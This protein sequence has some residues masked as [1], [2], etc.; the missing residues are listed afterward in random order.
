[1]PR[2]LP[3]VALLL[4]AVPLAAQTPR[5][6]PVK[7]AASKVVAVTVYQNTALVTREVTL[8]EAAG[9]TEVVVSPLPPQT[10]QSS[11]YAEGGDG[12]RVLSARYRTRAIAEDTREEVR[13]LEAQLK[14]LARKQ[15]Q[16]QADHKASQQNG[17]FLTKL[18][19]FTSGALNHLSDKGQLDSEKVIAL[20]KF[21]Q[22]DR[23][24]RA[25]EEVAL[26]QQLELLQEQTEFA[27]RQLAEVSG[28]G[29][30]TE[31]DAVVVIDKKAGAGTVRLN[32]LVGQANWRPQYKLRAPA[33]DGEKVAVEYLAAVEQQ[34]G[35]DWSDVTLSL[36]TAQPLLN[37]APPDLRALEVSVGGPGVGFG[38]Q[39]EGRP[40]RPPGNAPVPS[41]PTAGGGPGG[42]GMP[43]QSAY[44]RDL[45]RQSQELRAQATFNYTQKKAAEGADLAN[46]AAALEQFKDLL[47]SSDDV[48]KNRLTAI[49]DSVARDGPSVTFHLKGRLSLPSRSDEQVL[50][51]ARLELAPKFYYKAVPVLTQ[52][53]YRLADLVNTSEHVLL[54][55]EA[56]MYLGTDFV[57]Q[58]RVPLVA[59]GKPFTVGFGV[60]PQLQVSR[61]LLDKGRT[62]QGGNQVLR[63]DYRILL[64]SYKDKPV[65]VQVWDR[66]PH[67]EAAQTIAVTLTTQK[68][69]LSADPLYVRD[70]KPRNLLRWD[71]TL[72]PKQSG[73]KALA[74]DYEYKLELER[75]VSIGAFL[76]APPAPPAPSMPAAARP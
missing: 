11:L 44:L 28:G 73:E 19:G 1:M 4:A 55:G 45:D 40:N 71:V 46:S 33:K 7:P 27:R 8:P 38:V 12:I 47:V 59:I 32:Y 63:F 76:A 53:V 67:A 50:E 24:R 61:T 49:A 65:Q 31:R 60:D 56:T 14:D 13:R 30:R 6:E 34:T 68:P 23:T 74:I 39:T 22:E 72:D 54:P 57:G 51:V 20:A 41:Q 29:V 62:T 3:A 18:E 69:D 10:M 21:V 42:G 64:S 17:Q 37:A 48:A 5:A 75:T 58:T 36:S 9:L 26:G 52:N 15:A 66:M 43:A 2:T 35:E 70:E 16:L 25:K